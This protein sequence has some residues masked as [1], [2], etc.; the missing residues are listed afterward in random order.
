MSQKG[1][2]HIFVVIVILL[3]GLVVTLKLSQTQQIFKPKASTAEQ[4]IKLVGPGVRYDSSTN[5]YIVTNPVVT[6]QIN[7]KFL[8]RIPLGIVPNADYPRRHLN[9][10][11]HH[12]QIIK[13]GNYAYIF[14]DVNNS[15]K[16]QL[17]VWKSGIFANV[18][19]GPFDFIKKGIIEY[20][21]Y[22]RYF[23]QASVFDYNSRLYLTGVGGNAESNPN[24]DYTPLDY[25]RTIPFFKSKSLLDDVEL[26]W[27]KVESFPTF[28]GAPQVGVGAV[29]YQGKVYLTGGGPV[30]LSLRT[31]SPGGSLDDWVNLTDIDSSGNLVNLRSGPRLPAA[32]TEHISL[33]HDGY[34]FV[35]GG[36]GFVDSNTKNAESGTTV[37]SAKINQDGSLDSW[38]SSNPKMENLQLT[39]YSGAAYFAFNNLF[40][41]INTGQYDHNLL[42]RA[43]YLG[44]GQIG[45]WEDIDNFSG[46]GKV[47][48]GIVTGS[49]S[50]EVTAL[51]MYK[52]SDE[53]EDKYEFATIRHI[54]IPEPSTPQYKVYF[55]ET[56][57]EDV[58]YKPLHSNTVD[59]TMPENPG[60]NTMKVK[61]KSKYGQIFVSQRI[62]ILYSPEENSSPSPTP[63]NGIPTP[64][65]PNARVSDLQ[66]Y[67]P[68]T[69]VTLPPTAINNVD[70]RVD[71]GVRFKKTTGINAVN[72]WI[73]YCERWNTDG[74][75]NFETGQII[76]QKEVPLDQEGEFDLTWSNTHPKHIP[77]AHKVGVHAYYC[78][79]GTKD[80]YGFPALY[81]EINIR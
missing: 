65:N 2:V 55:N 22:S 10:I 20:N 73:D 39:K 32:R 61:V 66:I 19:T 48:T 77:G 50:E 45:P 29:A 15:G 18:Y 26:E 54:P 67:V 13:V 56:N 38:N 47:V 70:S 34:L 33:I 74:T 6:L 81:Q 64:P 41:M 27:E 14:G 75:C 37:F 62:G 25:E 69:N 52:K 3:V 51:L 4:D 5:Q 8:D 42:K 59:I 11:K 76:T 40:A 1:S 30:D 21:E 63:S 24:N 44:D 72:L 68:A 16:R 36:R 23:T 9:E 80:C 28:Q 60:S 17:T 53:G 12:P 57:G 46:T 43:K 35:V 58:E 7:Q 79:P 78:T 71:L 31:R 49:S